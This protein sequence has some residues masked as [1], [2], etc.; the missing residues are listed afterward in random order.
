MYHLR[1]EKSRQ[2]GTC[3]RFFTEMKLLEHGTAQN[4]KYAMVEQDHRYLGT[5]D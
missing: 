3:S 1:E 5:A 2:C 4:L